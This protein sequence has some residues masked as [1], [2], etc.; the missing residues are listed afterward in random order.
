[1]LHRG[2]SWV[3]LCAVF[4][5][6]RQKCEEAHCAVKLKLF[7]QLTTQ[8]LRACHIHPFIYTFILLIVLKY[9]SDFTT[10]KIIPDFLKFPLNYFLNLFIF[11]LIFLQFFFFF[12][13]I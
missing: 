4:G 13:E 10:S 6:D 1:M 3:F 8:F 11:L 9:F 5:I 12:F 7:F 2:E